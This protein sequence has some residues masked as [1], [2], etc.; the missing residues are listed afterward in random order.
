MD[1]DIETPPNRR[2]SPGPD[3]RER[4]QLRALAETI[5]KILDASFVLPGSSIRIGLDPLLGLVPGIGDVIANLIGSSL[6]FIATRLG[7]PR[8][9]IF[10]MAMNI[11]L[12][13]A[14]GIIPGIG[15][16]FSVWFRSN[17]RNAYLLQRYA[18]TQSPPSTIKDWLYVVSLII[19]MLTVLFGLVLGALWILAR[20]W[21]M[22]Q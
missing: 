4:E 11:F 17:L 8:I 12:N 9:V 21:Q 18:Q 3:Q 14:L 5:A 2:R 22:V 1:I 20:L 13:M 15:D 10:R 19:L 7:V 6:L 16:L